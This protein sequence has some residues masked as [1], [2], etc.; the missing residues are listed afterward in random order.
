ME[1]PNLPHDNFVPDKMDEN[2]NIILCF[3]VLNRIGGQ[4][5]YLNVVIVYKDGGGGTI[6]P[7][8]KVVQQT[9]LKNNISYSSVFNFVFV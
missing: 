6:Q 2:I 4:V 8:K 7:T 3:L 5:Y 9:R 1:N